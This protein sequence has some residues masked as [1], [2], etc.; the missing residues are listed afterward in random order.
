MKRSFLFNTF[1]KLKYKCNKNAIKTYKKDISIIRRTLLKWKERVH[2]VSLPYL[3]PLKPT[4]KS[5][6]RSLNHFF[7]LQLCFCVWSIQFSTHITQF[8]IK[9]AIFSKMPIYD[10]FVPW[11]FSFRRFLCMSDV[12]CAC[13]EIRKGGGRSPPS[14]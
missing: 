3:F 7:N 9:I 5:R 14:S 10:F 6:R 13:F 11:E 2:S 4:K 1:D 8:L 12:V